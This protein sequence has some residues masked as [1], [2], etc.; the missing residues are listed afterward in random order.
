MPPEE[1]VD[2]EDLENG[3]IDPPDNENTDTT[4]DEKMQAEQDK[5]DADDKALDDKIHILTDSAI[6]GLDAK[7]EW[8][9]EKLDMYAK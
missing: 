6:G 8:I 7:K 2:H 4:E 5:A 9:L 3:L 1:P